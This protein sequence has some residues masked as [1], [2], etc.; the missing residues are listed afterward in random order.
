MVRRS[1]ALPSSWSCSKLGRAGTLLFDGATWDCLDQ[2]IP[3]Y[4]TT[5]RRSKWRQS[6]VHVT[7]ATGYSGTPL[8]KKLGVKEGSVVLLIDAPE[9]YARFFDSLPADVR[10]ESHATQL[11]DIAHV[12]VTQRTALEKHLTSLR[13]KLGVDASV[14]VSWPKKAAKV[15]T[16]VTED[17][18]RRVALPMGFV[19]IK[20]CAVSELWSGLRLVVRKELR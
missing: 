4:D 3:K 5:R 2:K 12:F 20:V 13:K 8:A 18:I 14:W 10:F 1:C 9:G 6:D 16:D 7:K 15:P 17:V 11:V 19:D